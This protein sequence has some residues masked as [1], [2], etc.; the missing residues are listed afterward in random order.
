M[1]ISIDSLTKKFGDVIGVENLTLHIKDGEFVAFLGPSGCGKT[2][3]LLTLAGIYK[4]TEGI[5]RF[6]QRIVNQVQ[7]KDL[8]LIHI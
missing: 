7:P 5:I 8:S 6:G 2:T 4:P 1:I 3:T